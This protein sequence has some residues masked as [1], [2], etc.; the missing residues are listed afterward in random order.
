MTIPIFIITF[1]RLWSLIPT[2]EAVTKLKG[3][4]QIIFCDN[5]SKYQPLIDWLKDREKEGYKVYWNKTSDLY[6]EIDKTVLE[7]YK[8]NDSDYFAIMDPDVVI[9][10]PDDL[11]EFYVHLFEQ[12]KHI[13]RVGLLMRYDDL[14]DHYPLKQRVLKKQHKLYGSQP[15]TTITWKNNEVKYLDHSSIDTTFTM[16]RKGFRNYRNYKNAIVTLAPYH[17]KH[18]DWYIDVNNMNE[19]QIQYCKR[20]NRFA[21]WCGQHLLPIVKRKG[22]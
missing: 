6:K 12:N 18:L 10:A 9:Q 15:T 2:F 5:N 19:D 14:P 22:L 21:H 8:T 20:Q 4:Y 13:H 16:F 7:W 3:D 11:L 1:N 17:A